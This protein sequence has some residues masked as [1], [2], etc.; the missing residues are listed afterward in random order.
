MVGGVEARAAEDDAYR[1]VDLAQRLLLTL[2]ASG[3]GRIFEVLMAV[4][5]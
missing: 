2:G 1:Q 4:K 3:Q 5:L